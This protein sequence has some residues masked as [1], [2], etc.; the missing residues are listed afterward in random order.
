MQISDEVLSNGVF[1]GE[2]PARQILS[3]R[4]LAWVGKGALA[5]TDQG[6]LSG[7]N[8]LLGVLLAR[9]LTPNQY[10]AFALGFSIFLF[11]SGLHN[12]FFL[13]PMSVL[14]PESYS[15]CI[16]GYLK[17]LLGLHFVFTF[18]LS[19]LTVAA[20][21]F[22]RFFAADQALTSALWGVS[23][24]VPLILFQW[25]CRRAA[26]LRLAPGLAAA[27]SAVYCLALILLLMVFNKQGWLSPFTGFLVPSLATFPAILMLLVSL[28]RRT[29]STAGPA[30]SEIVRR[31]W[32]YGRW[33]V[34]GTTAN[35]LSGN[36]YYLIV[37]ALLPIG[38][39][40]AFRALRN[41]TS[42]CAQ[43]LVAINLLVL[44]WASARFAKEGIPGL[45][46]RTRQL[47]WLFGAAAL[48]YLAAIW[49]F[50]SK[51]MSFL[52]AGRYNQFAPLLLLSTAPLLFTAVAM[53][54]EVA[55]QVMQAPSEVFL[56][57]SVSGALTVLTGIVFT[58]YWGLAGGLVGLLISAIAFWVVITYRYHKR[59][60]AAGTQPK[61]T[62]GIAPAEKRVVWLMPNV[63][64]AYYWQPVF[65]EFTAL[66]P[67][68]VIF[69]GSWPGSLPK[70]RGT[71]EVRPV[72]G[73]RFITFGKGG[74]GYPRGFTLA[75]PTI[76][77]QL[78]RL[79]PS[80]ILTSGLNLWSAFTLLFKRITK[81]RVVLIWEGVS[82]SIAGLNSPLR[83]AVRRFMVKEFDAAISNTRAGAQYLQ[84]ILR[85]P[86]DRVVQH[87]IEVAEEPALKSSNGNHPVER[88]DTSFA[89]LVVGQLIE[90]K[91]IHRLFEAARL[92][93]SRGVH[94]F[95][96]QIVGTGEMAGTLQHQIAGSPLDKVVRWMG[97]VS[98]EKLGGCYEACDAVVFPSLEDTWG[99]VVLEAMCLGRPV[100][101]SKYAGSKEMIQDG[102][103]GFVFD[104]HNPEELAARMELLLRV[105]GLAQRL[106]EKAKEII[107]PYTARLAAQV[108]AQVA[109]GCERL[110][111]PHVASEGLEGA[112]RRQ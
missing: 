62:A 33:V 82:P 15:E 105:P 21:P 112:F 108:L 83:L 106:G 85:M 37:A 48:A 35:W 109:T 7:S 98:Y 99:M 103:N 22:L 50:G 42:P 54:S 30:G 39:L 73:I 104:P 25:L 28:P 75:L 97:P 66:V 4:Q 71:F 24:A 19:M 65:K 1:E 101:C 93:L 29:D 69:A 86:S 91:G 57:Y 20:I 96:I 88:Q 44:P 68:T 67:K 102:E 79:R 36:A 92:L 94:N 64:G 31:H 14:G 81:C 74:P 27:S 80:V 90:R 111:S 13:E 58:H 61:Q 23:V 55:V 2:K 18:L 84:D 45:R 6:L 38:D 46:R 59:S 78:G 56:A 89:F 63:A 16:V 8:F 52:Y 47:A 41:F 107:G 9:W 3:A 26:Y 12:A 40:A 17:K 76:L 51:I 77:W 70:Y 32:E 43:A 87:P 5:I 34:G 53:G 60:R 10:G 110:D 100:L 72:R 11:L 49:L 95:T